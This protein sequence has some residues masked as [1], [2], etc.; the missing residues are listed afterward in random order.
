MEPQHP[1]SFA[2]RRTPP[3]RSAGDFGGLTCPNANGVPCA[4]TTVHT[5]TPGNAKADAEDILMLVTVHNRGP[6]TATIHLLQQLWFR[7][8]WSWKPN[9]AKPILNLANDGAIA[10]EHPELRTYRLYTEGN[11][12]LLFCD[13]ETNV[14]RLFSQQD[15]QGHFKDAFHEYAVNGN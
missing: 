2:S 11:P 7:N 12:A 13:N 4:R 5:A 10:T 9:S 8:T 3:G 1:S 15:V 6:E 14:R